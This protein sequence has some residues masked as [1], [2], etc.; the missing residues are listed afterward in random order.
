MRNNLLQIFT[1]LH[2]FGEL[3]AIGMRQDMVDETVDSIL[4]KEGRVEITFLF[5]PLCLI[6]QCGFYQ[7]I[8]IPYTLNI[9]DFLLVLHFLSWKNSAST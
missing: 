3:T 1:V 5:H 7:H 2:C 8:M 9:Y 4:V 6:L